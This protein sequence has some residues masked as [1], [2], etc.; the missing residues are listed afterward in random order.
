M[1]SADVDDEVGDLSLS[2]SSFRLEGDVSSSF[3]RLD[4]TTSRTSK[5]CQI[6]ASRLG[7]ELRPRMFLFR[8][9]AI[10]SLQ[11]KEECDQIESRVNK[12]TRKKCIR[13]EK[14]THAQAIIA[15]YLI[16]QT[17]E[18]AWVQMIARS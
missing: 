2:N 5:R 18:A 12:E 10:S 11:E 16:H 1:L 9:L 8:R 17:F 13:K 7:N 14:L 6:R 3:A 4:L 15:N